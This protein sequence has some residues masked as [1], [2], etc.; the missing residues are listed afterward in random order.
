MVLASDTDLGGWDQLEH[1]LRSLG[2]PRYSDLER[3]AGLS[4]DADR[5]PL[6]LVVDSLSKSAAKD[7]AVIE[8][9]VTDL[10]IDL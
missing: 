3:R 2:R 10:G 6:K 8:M 4:R 1:D 7:L 5:D 9:E